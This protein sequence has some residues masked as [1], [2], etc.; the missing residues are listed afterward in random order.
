MVIP[1]FYEEALFGCLF[2]RKMYFHVEKYARC[3]NLIA[4]I[5]QSPSELVTFFR[6]IYCDTLIVLEMKKPAFLHRLNPHHVSATVYCSVDQ[7]I[8]GL[9]YPLTGRNCF[10][11]AHSLKMYSMKSHIRKYNL[12]VKISHWLD[13]ECIGFPRKADRVE[14]GSR[15]PISSLK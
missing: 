8:G 15:R 7:A 5:D 4:G 10:S 1:V 2:S 9:A 6:R 13:N 3:V 14:R 11:I 12:F